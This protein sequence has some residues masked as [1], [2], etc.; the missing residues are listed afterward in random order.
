MSFVMQTDKVMTG[1]GDPSSE[2]GTPVPLGPETRAVPPQVQS[3]KL[4]VRVLSSA[5]AESPLMVLSV[6]NQWN[7]AAVKWS[8]APGLKTLDSGRVIN[9]IGYNYVDWQTGP[10]PSIAGHIVV[11]GA[12]LPGTRHML[13]FP[14]DLQRSLY[15]SCRLRSSLTLKVL[16][17]SAWI[18]GL[19]YM[20]FCVCTSCSTWRA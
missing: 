9:Q 8:T 20:Y 13:H 12:A 10:Q 19:L 6:G 17:G 18:C 14:E 3:A 11:P 15:S 1:S 5:S 7:Q 4:A 16:S 2:L